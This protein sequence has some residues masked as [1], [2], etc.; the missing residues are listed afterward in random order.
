MSHGFSNISYRV[1]FTYLLLNQLKNSNDLQAFL[2]RSFP[3]IYKFQR[4]IFQKSYIDFVL[5]VLSIY[6]S[7]VTLTFPLV[8]HHIVPYISMF[9]AWSQSERSK[10]IS[11]Y[12]RASTEIHYQYDQPIRFLRTCQSTYIKQDTQIYTENCKKYVKICCT[13]WSWIEI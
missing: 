7:S 1:D 9:L 11:K 6:H 4:Y 12:G 13:S 10:P 2:F 3:G 8:K 5:K